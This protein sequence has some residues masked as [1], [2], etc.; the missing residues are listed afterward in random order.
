[1][2]L[3]EAQQTRVGELSTEFLHLQNLLTVQFARLKKQNSYL[4][5]YA[6]QTTQFTDP[7]VKQA[8]KNREAKSGHVSTAKLLA[9][10][11]IYQKSVPGIDLG[12]QNCRRII[13]KIDDILQT[14]RENTLKL[15]EIAF[16]T[17]S[18]D[19][20]KNVREQFGIYDNYQNS[21][22]E[23]EAA[24]DNIC[25]NLNSFHGVL[26]STFKYGPDRYDDVLIDTSRLVGVKNA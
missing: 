25:S 20:V 9:A 3:T 22:E 1:M 17:M 4:I 16:E 11:N 13:E 2:M 18:T 23:S 26:Y 19:I 7:I 8:K 6:T 10:K 14:M 5:Q 24:M 15:K 12:I 21:L